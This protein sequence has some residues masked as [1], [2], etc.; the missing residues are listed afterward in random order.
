MR[1]AHGM[2]CVRRGLSMIGLAFLAASALAAKEP[3]A[4]AG[5][6]AGEAVARSVS[7][8]RVLVAL[9]E[10]GSGIATRLFYVETREPVE[11]LSLRSPSARVE[12]SESGLVVTLP[13]E[14]RILRFDLSA[15]GH[16][17]GVRRPARTAAGE[18]DTAAEAAPLEEGF[19]PTRIARV[20]SLT[21][22]AGDGRSLDALEAVGSG[23]GGFL[24]SLSGNANAPIQ[25]PPDLGGDGGGCSTSCKTLCTSCQCSLNC[26][27]GCASCGCLDNGGCDCHC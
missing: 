10:T 27:S 13:R 3:T 18:L 26:S 19:E 1:M 24:Q 16:R 15:G 8:H 12:S 22:Y 21:E 2:S 20:A 23:A 6:Y 25:H 7:D 5:S 14:H 9:D 17:P 11:A 4:Q